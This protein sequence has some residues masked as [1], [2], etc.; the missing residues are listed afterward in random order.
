MAPIL[1]SVNFAQI[2]RGGRSVARN[3]SSYRRSYELETEALPLIACMR[4]EVRLACLLSQLTG[5][6]S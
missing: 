5:T 1:R 3:F 6:D 4:L 2:T